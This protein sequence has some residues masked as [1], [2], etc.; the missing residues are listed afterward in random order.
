[1]INR[2]RFLAGLGLGM[3]SPMLMPLMRYVTA[4]DSSTIPKRVVF[5][6]EGNGIEPVN[7]LSDKARQRIDTFGAGAIDDYRNFHRKY[8]HTSPEIVTSDDTLASARA[9]SALGS[10][11]GD[12]DLQGDAAVLFGLSSLITGAGHTSGYGALTSS[13]SRGTVPKGESIDCWLARQDSVRGLD[14]DMDGRGRTPFEAFRAGIHKEM[15]RQFVYGTSAYGPASPAPILIGA[16]A[17]YSFLFSSIAGGSAGRTFQNQGIMLEETLR[18]LD[19]TANQFTGNNFER[20]KIDTYRESLLSIKA[21]REVLL[22]QHWQDT[23]TNLPF[24]GPDTN[25]LFSSPH[26][27]QRLELHFELATSAL[28][29]GLTNV[30]VIA[31]GSGGGFDI[32]YT[33]LALPSSLA[34]DLPA[35]HQ[36]HHLAYTAADG[37]HGN[38]INLPWAEPL[39]QVTERHVDL[40]A[41]MARAL[42]ASTESDGSSTLDHTIIVYMPDNGE[43]H[44]ASG[45]EWPVLLVGGKA[46]GFKTDGRSV[47][48]PGVAQD[49][50]HRQMSN[51]FNTLTHAVQAEQPLNDFGDEGLEFVEGGR[52]NAYGPLS[53]IWQPV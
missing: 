25:T 10:Q 44:H 49:D 21:R 27:L 26:P 5:V 32:N 30:A 43:T 35:R 53:E 19:R 23:L 18:Q 22:K 48:Y 16:E 3:A 11:N 2:R 41:K 28:L 29:G 20:N 7:L 17:A 46:L 33:D 4:N 45:Q 24:E 47:I 34:N 13:R 37:F 12:V 6:I 8:V 38:S 15:H 51:L 39:R 40:I 31:S 14:P 52:R 42:K 36:T 9:L 50:G 1:M